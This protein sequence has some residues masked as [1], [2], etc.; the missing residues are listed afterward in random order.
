MQREMKKRR[1]RIGRNRSKETLR[2]ILAQSWAYGFP[3]RLRRF[4]RIGQPQQADRS[5]P[6]FNFG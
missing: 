1:G 6:L 5:V 2:R 4:D 3:R